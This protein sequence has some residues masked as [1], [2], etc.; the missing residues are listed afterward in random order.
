[1]ILGTFLKNVLVQ[2]AKNWNIWLHQV[3]FGMETQRIHLSRDL[4]TGTFFPW[5]PT[6]RLPSLGKIPNQWQTF[7]WSFLCDSWNFRSSWKWNS[8]CLYCISTQHQSFESMELNWIELN[9]MESES[10]MIILVFISVF[11]VNFLSGMWYWFFK[12][13]MNFSESYRSWYSLAW[14]LPTE[15]SGIVD[16]QSVCLSVWVFVTAMVKVFCFQTIAIASQQNTQY[17][18]SESSKALQIS[19][20]SQLHSTN[21]RIQ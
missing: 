8:A 5:L 18:V 17:H 4:F 13:R 6:I 12:M 14:W 19:K 11:K 21:S 20:R 3:W 16:S 1:L 10:R 7:P 9:G 15:T 2:T